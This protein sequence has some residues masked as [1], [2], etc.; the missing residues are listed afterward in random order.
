M[1]PVSRAA[2]VALGGGAGALARVVL[3]ELLPSAAGDPTLVAPAFLV[4]NLSGSALAGFLRGLLERESRRGV[5]SEGFLERTE[6]LLVTGF[7]G[8]YTSYSAFVA[9]FAGG[10]HDAPLLSTVLA[11][12]TLVLCPL[13]ALAGMGLSGGYPAPPATEHEGRERPGDDAGRA[14]AERMQARSE[15]ERP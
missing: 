14:P 11:V 13:A 9:T 3:A 2:L 4:V 15:A 10:L 6:A 12:A 7:C 8:G 5:V 1:T